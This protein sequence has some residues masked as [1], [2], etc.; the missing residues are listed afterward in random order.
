M[1]LV[2]ADFELDPENRR[3]LRSGVEVP[4]EGRSLDLLCYLAAHPGRL[5]SKAELVS[6]VWRSHALSDGALSSAVAKLR[7]ALEQGPGACMPIETVYGHGYRWHALV[8]ARRIRRDEVSSGP[9]FPAPDPFVG[10]EQHMQV[11]SAALEHV[12]RGQ[13]H[14]VVLRGEA[15]IGK[16]RTLGELARRARELGFSVWEG[17]AHDGGGAPSYWPWTELLRA[18]REDLCAPA[19]EQHLPAG[20]VA[21]PRLVPELFT[22]AARDGAVDAQATRFLLFD[23]LTR[24]LRSAAATAPRLIVLEDLHWANAATLELL[25]Y[26][27]R[28]LSKQRV[29]F[30]ASWR[31]PADSLNESQGAALRRLARS[32]TRLS[33]RGMSTEEI[34]ELVETLHGGLALSPHAKRLFEQRTRGN[35]LFIRQIVELL[36][37]RGLVPDETNLT[38][39]ELP[40]AVVDVIRQRVAPL[41]DAAR[42]AL[43]VAAVS[44]Q[45]CDA[46][47]LAEVL[48]SPL[49]QTL[50]ALEPALRTG[51]LERDASAPARFRFDHA[52]VKEALYEEITLPERGA[53]HAKLG[54]ALASRNDASDA[55]QLA[56][57][58][59]HFLCALPTDLEACTRHCRRAADAARDAAAFEAAANLL[60]R[61]LQKLTIEGG[62]DA[63]RCEL[64]LTLGVDRYWAGDLEGAWQTLRQG[65]LLAQR[66]QRVEL[67][68]RFA[69]RLLDCV[70]MTF[71]DEEFVRTVIE[72]ALRS[73]A[74]RDA[75]LRAALLA[76]RAEIAHE[77]PFAERVAMLDEADALTTGSDSAPLLLAIATCRAMLRDP[78]QL[79]HNRNAAQRLQTLV[80]LHPRARSGTRPAMRA[81]PAV[82]TEYLCALTSCNL[83]AA[84][85]L[86]RRASECVAEIHPTAALRPI[87]MR[88]LVEVMPAG[89]TLGDGRFEDLERHIERLREL[90]SVGGWAGMWWLYYTFLLADARGDQQALS[91]LAS[92]RIPASFSALRTRQ[93]LSV[94]ILAA[95]GYAKVGRREDARY[96]LTMLPAGDL[97]RMPAGY[98]DLG[99]LCRLAE[100][101]QVLDETQ[102]A[103]QLYRQLA[104]HAALNA[105]GP[106]FEYCGSV[107]HYV[108]ILAALLGDAPAAV[109][110]L[111]RA[112]AMNSQLRM[113]VQRAR[114]SAAL[115][116]CAIAPA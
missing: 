104:P 89:R 56:D 17:A 52:L 19:W 107:A 66:D 86:A 114:T 60:S 109:R 90:S 84:D 1:R 13:G 92:V 63:T 72:D 93:R 24:L 79:E 12:A 2:F 78:T 110:Y 34:G 53:L 47:L 27:A 85:V 96:W 67:L 50:S 70:D 94:T 42:K 95:W 44:G 45:V 23:E 3:L 64:M 32:A 87:Q 113:P 8:R 25:G 38:A 97:A 39:V 14:L 103:Q 80:A 10:R 82:V 30:A 75:G 73:L 20:S 112:R 58:A 5:I 102:A 11:L 28:S 40:P 55:R 22:G 49:P 108:G 71:G 29:L 91:Q 41:P 16:T 43:A 48:D 31:E 54:R 9:A 68:P 21:L 59:H 98:G 99:L 37:E 101:Y 105:V 106:C 115:K 62:D 4:L 15:G 7:R 46:W 6:K 116:C 33:L 57:I 111:Q 76:H 26:A 100:V 74:D 18:C 35:P 83:E 77:L 65:A 36:A 61:L 81:F 51:V 69:F 88:L